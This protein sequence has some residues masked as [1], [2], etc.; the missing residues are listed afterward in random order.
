M[1][2]ISIL[3]VC[4][5]ILYLIVKHYKRTLLKELQDNIESIEE[6]LVYLEDGLKKRKS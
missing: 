2:V 4:L 3:N 5:F 1:V 6:K